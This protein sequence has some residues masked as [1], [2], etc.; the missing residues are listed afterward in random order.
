MSKFDEAMDKYREQLGLLNGEFDDAL[1]TQIAKDLGPSIYL[2][3]A[4]KV[5]C[6]DAEEKKRVRNNFLI[7]KLG[8]NDTTEVDEI[9][10][11]VCAEMGSISNKYRAVFYYLLVKNTDMAHRIMN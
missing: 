3:D 1:L 4:S 2:N 10:E 11:A 8:L 9:V 5:S 7:G 6:S